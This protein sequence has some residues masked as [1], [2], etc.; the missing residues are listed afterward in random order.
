MSLIVQKRPQALR[1]IE[2]CFVFIAEDDLEV[3]LRFLLAVE[4]TLNELAQL[5]QIGRTQEFENP[6]LRGIRMWFVKGFERY[7]I[8]YFVTETWIDIIRLIH[9]ARDIENQFN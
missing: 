3:G 5:P 6:S 9:S 7:L 4:K 2:K 8:F 1:D